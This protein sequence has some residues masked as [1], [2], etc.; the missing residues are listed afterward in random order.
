MSRKD[1]RDDVAPTKGA[2]LS[3]EEDGSPRNGVAT[4]TSPLARRLSA[5]QVQ[6][7]ALGGTIGSGLFLGMATFSHSL[8][9][10]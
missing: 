8:C 3:V 10:L 2:N 1:L 9:L 7:I 5:R 4:T 6:M